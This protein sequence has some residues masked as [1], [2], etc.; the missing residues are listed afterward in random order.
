MFLYW[1][2]KGSLPRFTLELAKA[3]LADLSIRATISVSRQNMNFDQFAQFGPSL[4]PVTTF[5]SP[6]GA[7]F[8][9]WRLPKLLRDLKRRLSADRITAVIDLMPHIWSPLI[10][11]AIKSAGV[12]Y[13]P[14]IHDADAHP[15]DRTALPK[16]WIDQSI[17]LADTVITLS[18]AVAGRL[19]ALGRLDHSKVVTLFHPDLSYGPFVSPTPPRA[20]EPARLLFLGRILGYKGLPLFLDAVEILRAGGLP[21]EVGVYGQGPL[22]SSAPRLEALKADVV[23][24]WLSEEEIA[25]VLRR[26]HAVVLSHTEAS[27]SGVAA[28]ALGA[29]VP[30]I[31]TPV[32]GLIEQV[33]DGRT[34]IIALR[35]DG[36]SL[37]EA[38]EDLVFNPV[39][40]ERI[41]E[42]ITA[43]RDERSMDRFAREC[44]AH[45]TRTSG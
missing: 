29:G 8:N 31:A 39:L 28:A 25:Q 41:C 45:A 17:G 9:L 33:A 34:G 14:I 7:L 24:R 2:R 3:A 36:P 4:F 42:Y 40:Y 44:A 38:I 15:G 21:V 6:M 37:A 23:N 20:G 27:Q 32:G 22:G 35:A 43:S 30:L 10:A 19:E 5:E 1:G 11:P 12:R 16:R 13:V 18:G 26:Y